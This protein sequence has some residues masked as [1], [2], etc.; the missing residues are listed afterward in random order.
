MGIDTAKLEQVKYRAGNIIAR[1]P[2]CAQEEGDCKGEH[3]FIN[4]TGRFGC[5]VYPGKSGEAHRKEIHKLVG[6]PSLKKPTVIKVVPPSASVIPDILKKDVL[7]HLGRI[8]LRH[9]R[10]QC[11]KNRDIVV[12]PETCPK[13][14]V[15]NV[16]NLDHKVKRSRNTGKCGKYRQFQI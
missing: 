7:G 15:P 10:R 3:L 8:K 4:R 14:A 11:Q 9:A 2:A 12:E 1:C 5:V 6:C 16:P 13:N